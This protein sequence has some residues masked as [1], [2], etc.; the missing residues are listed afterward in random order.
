MKYPRYLLIALV[1]LSF[2][3]GEKERPIPPGT[4]VDTVTETAPDTIG[5]T[6]APGIY[7]QFHALEPSDADLQ[8]GDQVYSG[9]RGDGSTLWWVRAAG[10]N[11]VIPP[12]M[13]WMRTV[14]K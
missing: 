9:K 12:G 2:A 7:D 3:C 10:D 4:V 6:I 5:T 11:S 14:R 1:V 8:N 13:W